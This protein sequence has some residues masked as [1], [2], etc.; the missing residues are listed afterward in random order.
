MIRTPIREFFKG[1]LAAPPI[2]ERG[3]S[4]FT[5]EVTEE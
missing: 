2:V 5:N 4:G 1:M 3:L